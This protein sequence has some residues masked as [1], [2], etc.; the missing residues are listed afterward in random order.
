VASGWFLFFSY[1]I[2]ESVNSLTI[3]RLHQNQ[4]MQATA[5]TPPDTST[6][7]GKT[8]YAHLLLLLHHLT[9]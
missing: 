1:T 3:L 4:N 6:R 8:K 7:K 9:S 2:L 5:A